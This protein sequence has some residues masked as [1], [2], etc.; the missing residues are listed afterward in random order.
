M[1][2]ATMMLADTTPA[3][4]SAAQTAQTAQPAAAAAKPAEDKLICR[5]EAV[6][7]SLMP[8]KTCRRASDMARDRQDQRENLERMQ[9]EVGRS[10]N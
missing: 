3:A 9:R 1:L 10:G 8:K 6:T 5:S 2:A 4:A 7:G